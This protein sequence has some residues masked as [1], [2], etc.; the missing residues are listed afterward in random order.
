[1]RR[2]ARLTV[3]AAAVMAIFKLCLYAEE[4]RRDNRRRERRNSALVTLLL[5]ISTLAGL[6]AALT[7]ALAELKKKNGGYAIDLFDRD[8]YDIISPDEEDEFE[9]IM[10]GELD[11]TN[12][13]A[14]EPHASHG[15]RVPVDDEATLDNF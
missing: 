14:A 7:S 6:F 4:Q 5:G 10:Q 1:M 9:S 2:A 12:D 8:E 15:E 11:G 13:D 3:A